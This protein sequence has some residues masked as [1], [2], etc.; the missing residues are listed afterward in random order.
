MSVAAIAEK[1]REAIGQ[2]EGWSARVVSEHLPALLAEA[3]AITSSPIYQEYAGFV[4]PPEVEQGIALAVR[5]MV[6]LARAEPVA[7]PEAVAA[8]DAPPA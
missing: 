2:A 7:A 6:K 5:E 4:L 3:E 8:P 1:I